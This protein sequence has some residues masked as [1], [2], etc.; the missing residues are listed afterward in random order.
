MPIGQRERLFDIHVADDHQHRVLRRVE[1]A[2]E[3]PHVVQ[4]GGVEVLELA[5]AVVG[6]VPVAEGALAHVDPGE[7]AIG[8]VEDV[9]ADLVLDHVA[10]VVELLLGDARPAHAVR[11]EP[12]RE[13]QRGLG[14][15]L[16]VVGVV[17]A[18]GAVEHPAVLL[19]ELDQ[20]HLREL[21]GALEHQVL[22]EVREAGAPARFEPEADLVVDGD[23]DDRRRG[24]RGDDDAQPVAE[25]PVLDRYVERER[26]VVR[27]RAC[28]PSAA[29]LA[30]RAQ[31]SAPHGEGA[32][33]RGH[34]G[35]WRRTRRSRSFDI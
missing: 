1:V 6:V 34:E 9:D 21:P 28:L 4:A 19:H 13:L 30:G 26:A 8:A 5:V 20:L 15:H 24:V 31:G 25:P 33:A 16:E 11:L 29:A 7:A 17:G 10:L 35:G 18:G 12:E 32:R 23:G 3:G 14:E 2:E 27:H 22:E